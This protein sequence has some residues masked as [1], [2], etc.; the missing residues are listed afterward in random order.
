MAEPLREFTQF[1]WMWYLVQQTNN[2]A[3]MLMSLHRE[4]SQIFFYRARELNFSK[5]SMEKLH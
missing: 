5:S 4:E 3:G 1:T 2:I